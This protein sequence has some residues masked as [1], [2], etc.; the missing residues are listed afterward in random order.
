MLWM[1][2]RPIKDDGVDRR[3]LEHNVDRVLVRVGRDHVIVLLLEMLLQELQGRVR[4]RMSQAGDAQ[5]GI[6]VGMHAEPRYT[7]EWNVVIVA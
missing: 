1:V 4:G 5:F 7:R 2:H 6:H 3:I